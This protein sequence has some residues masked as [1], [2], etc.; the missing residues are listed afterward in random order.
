MYANLSTFLYLCSAV[1]FIL[2]LRGLSNTDMARQGNYYAITG[3]VIAILTTLLSPQ[4]HGYSLVLSMLLIGGGI[5]FFVASHLSMSM[6]PQLM[7]GFHSLVGLSAVLVAA[8]SLKFP[9]IFLIGSA[10]DLPFSTLLEMGIGCS[11]GA[12]TFT[13][14]IVA[15]LKLQGVISSHL[16]VNLKN[17]QTALVS[18]LGAILVILICFCLN[19]S[20]FLFMV[21]SLIS[22]GLGVIFIL[23]I[24]GADM[25]VVVSMLNSFSGW[26]AAGIGFTL[27][28]YLLVI[29]GAL[30]GSSGA[31]LSHIMCKAMNRSLLQVMLGSIS[32]RSQEIPHPGD[33]I[34]EDEGQMRI[35][36]AI[37][38]G[39]V[40]KKAKSVIIVPGYGMAV[41]RAQ[42]ALKDMVT[43]LKERGVQ[44]RYAVH[45]VA[46]RMPGHMNVLLAEANVSYEDIVELDQI[47]ADFS[48]TD[49]A[50]VVGA[51]DITNPAAKNDPLSPIYGMAVCDVDLAK[52]VVFVK[53]SLAT[54]YAGI[55]NE[56]FTREGTLLL[57]G[58]A[59]KMCETLCKHLQDDPQNA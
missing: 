51:N 1:C 45:P 50:F 35:A 15:F 28:N 34:L 10:N 17:F 21:L 32:Q 41:S 7:A 42:H 29:T 38:V 55:D 9:Q 3:M 4:I 59:K 43:L 46:G 23:P 57:L 24:G 56:L 58:D 31:V 48:N 12:I 53:R 27:N 6:L 36:D 44:V 26:S 49:V 16:F 8:S 2:S 39:D 37:Q 5:G 47:N 30:V 20:H 19:G 22:L 54:G 14:S 11:I 25:P 40:L 33:V 52:V 13:G 18:A